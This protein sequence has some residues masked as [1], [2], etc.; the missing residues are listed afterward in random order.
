MAWAIKPVSSAHEGIY[1]GEVAYHTFV[2]LPLISMECLC[3]LTE[4]VRTR[5]LFVTVI[6]KQMFVGVFPEEGC[7]KGG[8]EDNE[9]PVRRVRWSLLE[10]T[11]RHSS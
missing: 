8:D 5:K 2:L 3:V 6:R 9:G 1:R 10:K 11:M 7:E 4:N